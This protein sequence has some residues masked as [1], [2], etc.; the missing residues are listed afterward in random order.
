MRIT[1]KIIKIKF[2]IDLIIILIIIPFVISANV[3]SAKEI[4]PP[5][6]FIHLTWETS[7]NVPQNYLGKVLVGRS[8]LI[9]VSAQVFVYSQNQYLNSDLWEYRWYLNDNLEK[10]GRNLKEFRFFVKS[11]FPDNYRVKLKVFFNK[12][13]FLEKEITIP[14]P[15]PQIVIKPV[16]GNFLR[17]GEIL[18]IIS[19]QIKLRAIPYFF[20]SLKNLEIKWYLDK[21]LAPSSLIEN[22]DLIISSK[23]GAKD[24]KVSISDYSDSLIYSVGEIKV[25]FLNL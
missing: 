23:D 1:I 10:A 22:G 18:E 24:V 4:S 15:S 20:P 25:N 16:G 14:I 5:P 12:S 21:K 13:S 9:K 2:L 7:G 8:G 19:P 6:N 11:Y 17:K 3:I